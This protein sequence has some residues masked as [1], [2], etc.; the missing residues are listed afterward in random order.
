M[1]VNPSS[2]PPIEFAFK[3]YDFE[4]SPITTIHSGKID[5]MMDPSPAEINCTPH[6]DK[7]LLTMKFKN[8]RMMIGSHCLPFGKGIR[9][10][11]K[12]LT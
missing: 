10:Y 1:P 4:N 8:E 3:E 9:L 11:K 6:V 2:R 5:P 12:K 7:P